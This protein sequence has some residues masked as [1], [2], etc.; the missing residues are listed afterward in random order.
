MDFYTVALLMKAA[1]WIMVFFQAGSEPVNPV[2]AQQT[3]EIQDIRPQ[4]AEYYGP[5]I[6]KD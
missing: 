2:I 4:H 1:Y 3:I 6:Y 5:F